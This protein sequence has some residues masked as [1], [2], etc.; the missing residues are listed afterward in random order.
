[1]KYFLIISLLV[2]SVIVIKFIFTPQPASSAAPVP[3]ILY[4]DITSGPNTGGENNN[5]A[6]LSIFGKNFGAAKG[7]NDKVTINGI[8][9]ADYK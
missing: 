5:G 7:A 9:V 6:Y 3:V 4:T 8:E 2:L 1:M